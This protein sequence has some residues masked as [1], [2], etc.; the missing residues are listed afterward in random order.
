MYTENNSQK[1]GNYWTVYSG[2]LKMANP[3]ESFRLLENFSAIGSKSPTIV[4]FKFNR[5]SKIQPQ[6]EAY[7]L[8]ASI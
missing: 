2:L 7:E 5:Y 3:L 6:N 1:T 4:E 8:S